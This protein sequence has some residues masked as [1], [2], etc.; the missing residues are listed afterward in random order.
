MSPEPVTLRRPVPGPAS[1]GATPWW[2]GAGGGLVL[3]GLGLACAVGGLPTWA[4]LL[5]SVG[6]LATAWCADTAVRLRAR[7]GVLHVRPRA[8]GLEVP[9]TP[10]PRGLEVLAAVV[11]TVALVAAL[12]A[13]VDDGSGSAPST[14]TALPT[15][16]LGVLALVAFWRTVSVVARRRRTAT[17]RLD[18]DAVEVSGPGG[19]ERFAWSDL[20]GVAQGPLRLLGHAGTSVPL[21]ERELASD[22][23]LVARLLGHYVDRPRDRRELGDGRAAERVRDDG[24]APG[25]SRQGR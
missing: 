10:L 11:L 17:V 21:P 22:P 4:W 2:V 6:A 14:L 20:T 16:G 8:G 25:E 9:G 18:A 13:Q 24:L 19:H 23:A 1:S 3:L 12:L 15:V 7:R 5:V